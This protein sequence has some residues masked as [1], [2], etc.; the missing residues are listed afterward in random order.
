[1]IEF[2]GIVDTIVY[3]NESN[4]Y[5]V[6][7]LKKDRDTIT[8]V[9]YL[10]LVSEGQSVRVTGQW[11]NHPE[12][13]QQ[14]K[15]DSY[16]EVKPNSIKGIE[17]YLA[18]GLIQGLGPV[19]AQ[20]I[21]EKFGID[22]LDI[23]EFNPEKLTEV[24]GIG[25]KKANVISEAFR[26]QR[27]LRNVMVFLQTYGI[28]AGNAIKIYKKYGQA[29]INIVRE[30]PYRL[31]TD[32]LG[33]GFRT[34]DRIAQSLGIDRSSRYR[35]MAGI[36]YILTEYCANAGH[37]YLPAEILVKE[38]C[39]L[40]G[41]ERGPIE[42][43][44]VY[45]VMNKE[46]AMENVDGGEA[47]YLLPF[48]HSELGVSK[49]I[50]ELL[51]SGTGDLNVE[52]DKEIREYELD[53]GIVLAGEQKEAIKCA[54][55]KGVVIITGGPGTGKT[56]I[57]KCI[58]NIMEKHNMKISL[59]APTGRAA[60][61]MTE[62]TGC[63]AKTLHRLLE[64]GYVEGED[65]MVF[66]KDDSDPIDADVLIIDEAS[67]IDI[68]LMNNFLKAVI[69]GTRLIIVGD[70]DQLPSVGP[71]N[72]LRDLIESG[73]LP[74]VRL[75]EIFRQSGE[76]MIVVNA[77]RINKGELPVL[78]ESGGDF[79]F[80]GSSSQEETLDKIIELVSVKIPR[81]IE[82]CD[83]VKSLQVMTPMRKGLCGVYN[84]NSSLQAVLNPSSKDKDEKNVRDF[85]L[86][87][88]DKVMQVKN[89]Y[90]IRWEKLGDTE[91]GMG[92][93]NGDMG[94]IEYIDNE[95]GLISVIYDDDKRVLYDFS[96][97]EELELAY[98]VTIHKSQGS[99]FK[100]TVI[101]AVWGPP[102][103]MTRNL[104]YTGVTRAR[105]LVVIVGSRQ[106]IAGMVSNNHITKRYSGLGSRIKFLAESGLY[107]L[108]F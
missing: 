74:V 50:V 41:V 54:V 69:P 81:F 6:A 4:G 98:A 30:N 52:I 89:N 61:R 103:L 83:P 19:T 85:V 95:N 55:D 99:E 2:E 36:K 75:T 31:T 100:V 102:M 17:K 25:E 104:L 29:T 76:S 42:E 38:A 59:A 97:I 66:L 64:M 58:L 11:V 27:E 101:P 14:L 39:S 5:T 24:E 37:T 93:F 62:A 8:I 45:M 63:E 96:T 88:G 56:T 90:N 91:E 82:D 10:P 12:Y 13:G 18:S 23:M 57:I 26:E 68:L 49:R 21:V 87:T 92:V 44:C 80:F 51:G 32:V 9:G 84:L 22:T 48:Y 53:T 40:L 16:D 67:M 35:L 107:N 72:V 33:I 3:N 73:L 78:N 34:A 86:R 71:G 1:M 65:N 15:I 94:Y 79:Y 60:K 43:A 28:T 46:L 7:K 106:V 20:R 70:V 105:E 77:H 47:V 108:R